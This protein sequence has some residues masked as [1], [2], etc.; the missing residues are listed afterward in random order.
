MAGIMSAGLGLVPQGERR[1][2]AASL[3]KDFK[4]A[5]PVPT[6]VRRELKRPSEARTLTWVCN[7]HWGRAT[8]EVVGHASESPPHE[9]V[10]PVRSHYDKIART[11]LELLQQDLCR[12]AMD[13][14]PSP[15]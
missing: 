9:S 3:I 4:R 8:K 13:C 11:V 2:Q 5:D 14:H 12:Q 1:R 6:G 10:S 7:K 15:G